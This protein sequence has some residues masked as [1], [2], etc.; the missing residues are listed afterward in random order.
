VPSLLCSLSRHSFT[1]P[2]VLVWMAFDTLFGQRILPLGV[3]SDDSARKEHR[4]RQLNTNS[5]HLNCLHEKILLQFQA[6]ANEL[7]NIHDRSRAHNNLTILTDN[8]RYATK[9][10][11]SSEFLPCFPSTA[12]PTRCLQSLNRLVWGLYT[13][14]ESSR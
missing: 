9:N 12:T 6:A 1:I 13:I 2:G 11:D 5:L 3:L 7:L 4:E 8:S 14:D 10:H